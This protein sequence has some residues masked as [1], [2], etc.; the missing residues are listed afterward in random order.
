MKICSFKHRHVMIGIV[1]TYDSVFVHWCVTYNDNNNNKISSKQSFHFVA[2]LLDLY[3]NYKTCSWR[4]FQIWWRTNYT[5]ERSWAIL[6]CFSPV[7]F[8]VTILQLVLNMIFNS[9]NL[10]YFRILYFFKVD[11]PSVY[12]IRIAVLN[13]F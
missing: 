9:V 1:C 7:L 4:D 3:V 13:S 12:C 6:L 2:L 10:M 11:D 5:W 8:M